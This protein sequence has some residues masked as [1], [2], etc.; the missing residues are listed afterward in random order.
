MQQTVAQLRGHSQ[1]LRLWEKRGAHPLDSRPEHRKCHEIENAKRNKQ[2]ATGILQLAS[3]K[4]ASDSQR[5][6]A[7]T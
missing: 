1:L 3:G 6:G 5:S 2:L 4:E 7:E